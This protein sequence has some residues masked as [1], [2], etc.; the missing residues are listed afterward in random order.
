MATEI[1]CKHNNTQGKA[2]LHV[3]RFQP[4]MHPPLATFAAHVWN[5]LSKPVAAAARTER[6]ASRSRKPTS[7]SELSGTHDSWAHAHAQSTLTAVARTGSAGSCVRPVTASMSCRCAA[8][9]GRCGQVCMGDVACRTA[10]YARWLL[11][12][13]EKALVIRQRPPCNLQQ[14]NHT[15]AI[16]TLNCAIIS[17]RL[18]GGWR[19]WCWPPSWYKH[20]D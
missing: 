6:L 15:L 18:R 1:A 10:D 3:R 4:A 8:G 12:R 11:N 13:V 5:T 14:R 16:S 7:S 20:L 9:V 19:P 2:C 17:N